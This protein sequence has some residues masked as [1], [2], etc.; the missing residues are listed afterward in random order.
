MGETVSTFQRTRDKYRLRTQRRRTARRE[1]TGR[2]RSTS[3][4]DLDLSWKFVVA[5]DG[6]DELKRPTSRGTTGTGSR[7]LDSEIGP[8]SWYDRIPLASAPLSGGEG[9]SSASAAAPIFKRPSSAASRT[10]TRT[11]MSKSSPPEYFDRR[12]TSASSRNAANERRSAS[13]RLTAELLRGSRGAEAG[14][15][16]GEARPPKPSVKRI[17]P[18]TPSGPAPPL[19]PPPPQ[20][21]QSVHP[22]SYAEIQALKC[23]GLTSPA[24]SMEDLRRA[25]KQAA[26]RCHPDRQQNHNMVEEATHQFQELCDAYEVLKVRL[27][28]G[29]SSLGCEFRPS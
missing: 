16:T 22:R 24:E 12:P 29:A 1:E 2:T 6:S 23:L 3:S 25:Y 19:R 9:N 27:N 5:W 8:P 18:P 14:D 17:R 4:K 11:G 10:S 13:N 20:A 21:H 26:L 15:L 28:P 7:T